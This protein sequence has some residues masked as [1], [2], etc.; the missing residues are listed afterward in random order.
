MTTS[1]NFVTQDEFRAAIDELNRRVQGLYNLADRMGYSVVVPEGNSV[2][3]STPDT[4]APSVSSNGSNA[5][6][7]AP[8][9]SG[10]DYN[11]VAYGLTTLK[12]E[13]ESHLGQSAEVNRVYADTVEWF[14]AC[15]AGDTAFDANTFRAATGASARTAC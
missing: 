11:A 1:T 12:T 10:V 5:T 15:F 13:I 4:D 8:T 6:T 14:A 3:E 2:P 7:P 9:G